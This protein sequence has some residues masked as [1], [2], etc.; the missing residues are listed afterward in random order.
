MLPGRSEEKAMSGRV[1]SLSREM[2]TAGQIYG[3]AGGE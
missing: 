2:Q 1:E 3:A